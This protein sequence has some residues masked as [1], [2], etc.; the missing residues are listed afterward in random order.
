MGP[1][2]E[3]DDGTE[4]DSDFKSTI[5]IT[6]TMSGKQYHLSLTDPCIT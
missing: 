3:A 1:T 2:L 5:V 4:D 6:V